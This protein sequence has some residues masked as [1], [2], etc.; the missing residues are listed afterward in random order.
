MAEHIIIVD[1]A[2]DWPDE[3]PPLPVVAAKDY[4]AGT[5]HSSSANLRVINL[6]RS[7]RYGRLGYYCSL[8]AEARGHR[9]IPSVR[10]IQDLSRR[11]IYGLMTRELDEQVEA[12]ISGQGLSPDTDHLR[13]WVFFGQCPFPQ[14]SGL[15]KQIFD[16]FRAPLLRVDFKHKGGWRIT[17]VRAVSFKALEAEQRLLFAQSLKGYLSRPWRKQKAGSSFKYE[18]AI[19]HDPK[20]KLPPSDND[21]LKRFIA[22]AR[23]LGMSAELIRKKDYGR[24]AEYD[25]LFIRET[26]SI[27]HHT[28]RFSRR[29]QNEGLVVMDD[30]DSILRCTNKVF[31]EELLRANRVSTPRSL[32]L[33]K[34]QEKD[35]HKQMSFPM[36]LKIPDGSFSR[37]VYKAESKKQL[38]D[39]CHRLF[40][41]SDL[42]LVQ[43]YMYTEFDW[44]VGVLDREP[45]FVCKY[46]M[47]SGH[48]QIYSH[49]K[50]DETESGGF[51]TLAVEDAPSKVL[52]TALRAANLVGDGLYGVDLKQTPDGVFV[53]EV[54]DNPSIDSGVE[55]LKLGDELYRKVMASFRRRLDQQRTK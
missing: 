38:R 14:L 11:S 29:A 8:L 31:L 25:A 42:I 35:L 55:D 52:K 41:E 4:L 10:T 32:I 27:D 18:L 19:L 26:T 21:A 5:N 28:F 45:L 54:N 17:G 22:A 47:T 30:P 23:E 13:V 15:V 7:Y 46:L 3:F 49:E 1:K 44:R 36:I 48:W 24:I 50:G 16:S 40:K 33:R 34:G 12:A 39:I 20:E 6:C 43:E 2:S 53:I 37:G 51:E 9:V